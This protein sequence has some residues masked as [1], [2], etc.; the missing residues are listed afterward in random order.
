MEIDQ[1]CTGCGECVAY[2]PQGAIAIHGDMASIDR[3]DCVECG[4]CLDCGVCPVQAIR[5]SDDEMSWVKKLFGRLLDSVPGSGTKGR[6]GGFD[7]KTND[8][9]GRIPEGMA[10]V[11]LELTRP[12]GGMT[13]Q[14]CQAFKQ[15][16][17]GSGYALKP[18][19]RYEV[20]MDRLQALSGDPLKE[21]VLSTSFEAVL[22]PEQVQDFIRSAEQYGWDYGLWFSVNCA[23][24]VGT[25][26][27]VN[28]V[29]SQSGLIPRSRAKVNLGM[30]RAEL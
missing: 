28:T 15:A 2:C 27:E 25:L 30:G 17:E 10:V 16:L 24:T 9:T 3:H 11:R 21:R 22:S 5:E 1:S 19:K 23:C 12:V 8:V 7:V 26:S 4:V 20:L 6:G 14:A 18:T 29:L 13:L